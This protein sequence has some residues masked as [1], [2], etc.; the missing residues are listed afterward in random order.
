MAIVMLK[1]N[2]CMCLFAVTMVLQTILICNA[3]GNN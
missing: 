1:P 3:C 2:A